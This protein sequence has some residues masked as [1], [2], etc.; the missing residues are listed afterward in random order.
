MH[1]EWVV[2]AL[3]TAAEGPEFKTLITHQ[4][5]EPFHAVGN[6]FPSLLRATEDDGGDEGEWYPTHPTQLH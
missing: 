2:R 3:A 5:S 1:F 4:V 6:G